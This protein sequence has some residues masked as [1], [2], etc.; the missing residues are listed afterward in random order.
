MLILKFCALSKEANTYGSNNCQVL[1]Q[2]YATA[3]T[4]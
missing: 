1:A 3:I 2:Y 4:P